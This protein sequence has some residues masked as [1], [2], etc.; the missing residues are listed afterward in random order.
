MD[1]SKQAFLKSLDLIDQE[2]EKFIPFI[3]EDLWELGSMPDYV[4][5]LVKKNINPFNIKKVVDF[6]CGKG[7]VLI[8]LSKVFDIVGLGIDIVPE[9]IESAKKYSIENKIS[10]RI[11]FETGDLKD[12]VS[13]TRDTDLV[14]F[15]GYDSTI[16]GNVKE[17]LLQL[18]KCILDQGWIIIEIAYTLDSK[19]KIEGLPSENELITQIND[20][21][22]VI[23]DKIIW[24]VAEIK[25]INNR[26]NSLIGERI[27]KLI[28]LHPDK[29]KLFKRYMDNQINECSLIENDMICSTWILKK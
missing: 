4:I 2:V 15:Y 5:K 23:I 6:G 10:D 28:A 19:S 26:N 18:K 21:E 8:K 3:L 29:K 20:S 7:A 17:S 22:L 24:D 1:D 25:R 27:K 11:K 13:N 12:Y 14:I 16:L 9:F